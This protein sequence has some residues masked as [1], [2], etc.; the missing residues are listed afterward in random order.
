MLYAPRLFYSSLESGYLSM[1]RDNRMEH[2]VITIDIKKK[3]VQFSND[4]SQL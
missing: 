1:A 3:N 2:E 4:A